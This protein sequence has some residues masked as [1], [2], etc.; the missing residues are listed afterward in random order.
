MLMPIMD[1]GERSDP[2]IGPGGRII[3]GWVLRN[4]P[5]QDHKRDIC[6]GDPEVLREQLTLLLQ[7]AKAAGANRFLIIERSGQHFM[8]C[9]CDDGGWLVE[10][11]EGDEQRHFRALAP[12]DVDAGTQEASLMQK[13]FAPTKHR[14]WYLD[15]DQVNDVM[16]AYLLCD[17]EP[18]WLE[19]D[20]YEL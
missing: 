17:P 7:Q 18:E 3:P 2:V 5:A 9:L 8:Q 11:R 16:A 10:K 20:R 19:W 15:M 13:I 4:F 1:K 12:R 14:S 6:S